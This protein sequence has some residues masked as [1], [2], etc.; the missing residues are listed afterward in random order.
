MAVTRQALTF[1]ASAALAPHLRLKLDGSNQLE[2]AGASEQELGTNPERALAADEYIAIDP[3]MPGIVVLMTAA[4]TFS[5][6]ASLYGAAAGKVDDSANENYIGIALDA[7]TAANDLVRVLRLQETV[8]IDPLGDIDGNIVID[9][10]FIGDY[11]DAGTA[12]PLDGPTKTETNGLGVISVDGANGILKFSFDNASEAATATLFYENSPIDIDDDPIF[13]CILAVYDIGDNAALDI[14]FGLASDDHATDF[15]SIAAFAAF[16]LDGND[17]SLCA[18]SDDGTTDTAAVDSD[19]DLVDDT[20]YAFKIDASDT[21]DVK[22]YYRALGTTDWTRICAGTTYNISEYSGTV[23][24]IVMV[25]KTSD[26]TTADVR[27]DRW[28]VQAKRSGV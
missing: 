18:H 27:L 25:E 7:A 5:Q 23:T 15:E 2:A 14:D 6:Y 24:P 3:L 17:L 9:D 12:L 22:F 20:Y 21:S 8:D 28:R 16:H 26:D 19:V 10:D 13:E 4:G 11:A 1:Q